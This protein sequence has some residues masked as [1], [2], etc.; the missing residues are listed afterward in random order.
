MASRS[1]IIKI[2]TIVEKYDPKGYCEAQH[3]ILY[4]F[5]DRDKMIISNEDKAKLIELGAHYSEEAE[6]W[7]V[8][9]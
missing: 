6:S 9:T 7:A 5:N 3:D 1:D 4:V 2:L 8:F